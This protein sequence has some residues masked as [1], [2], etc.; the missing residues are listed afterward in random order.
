MACKLIDGC[1][2]EHARP[3]LQWHHL[4]HTMPQ[5]RSQLNC[6]T[7]SRWLCH[8]I[9]WINRLVQLLD[10][11]VGPTVGSTGWSNCWINRLVQLLDNRLVQLLD[12]QVGPV[13][14][15]GWSNCFYLLQGTDRACSRL[16]RQ[17]GFDRLSP[18]GEMLI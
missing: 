5:K 14:S 7:L 17:L 3:H 13:E 1:S 18:S 6:R 16:P 12:Q 11:Q 2:L 9:C 15:T 4:L 8:E 10:Q